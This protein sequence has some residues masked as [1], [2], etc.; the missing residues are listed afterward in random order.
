MSTTPLAG[1][2]L[3]ELFKSCTRDKSLLLIT[4]DHLK[5]NFLPSAEYKE[6]WKSICDHFDTTNR[7]IT[8]GMLSQEFIEDKKVIKVLSKIRTADDI[9]PKD[10]V[11]Q[12]ELFIKNKIFI[13]AYDELPDL[14]NKNNQQGAFDL[15]LEVANK[16]SEFTLKE[17]TYFTK[18]YKDVID[19]HHQRI[20]DK[21]NDDREGISKD[22]I[23]FGVKPLDQLLM[24]GIPRGN[25][26]LLLASTGIG[27]SK[28]AKWAGISASRRGMRV[29]H[30]QGEGTKREA[31]DA[32]DAGI[33]GLN[34]HKLKYQSLSPSDIAEIEKAM[35]Q[36]RHFG[37]EIYMKAYEQFDA[38]TFRDIRD[39]VQD[40]TDK[41]GPIDLLIVDYLEL[42]DP[43][44]G[45]RYATNNE[46][47]RA[48]R[49]ACAEAFKNICVEFNIAGATPTQANDVPPSLFND[50]TFVLTRHNISE[51]KGSL[52]PFTYFITLNQTQDEKKEKVMRLHVDKA[53]FVDQSMNPTMS[54][55]TRFDVDRFYDH[56]RTVKKFGYE[57]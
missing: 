6:V 45:K 22:K 10:A 50:P 33:L 39:Y 13:E 28:M 7:L 25:T 18:I 31:E 15:M 21:E 48:R 47:E 16:L 12:L 9:H 3:N 41:E 5:Y 29:L 20:I 2:F 44:N 56:Q 14:Y 23:P 27:K 53:R 8:I 49:L 32:Y 30:V 46:G 1:N 57:Q 54:I 34:V 37:G 36:I 17:G 42:F 40:I 55:C 26:A 51:A 43:G 35:D 19:R 24:G 38:A 52:K 4:K 11:G